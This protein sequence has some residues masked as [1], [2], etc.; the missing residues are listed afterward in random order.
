MVP[1]WRDGALAR[2]C[3][4]Q[5]PGAR[6]VSVS[7]CQLVSVGV[8]G[9]H[10]IWSSSWAEGRRWGSR[11]SIAWLHSRASCARW[12]RVRV[13]IMGSQ[14]CRIEGNLSQFLL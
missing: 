3:T 6:R 12:R 13:E 9:C 4:R 10:R 8:S 7:W 2:H 11:R 14:K 5:P 1:G